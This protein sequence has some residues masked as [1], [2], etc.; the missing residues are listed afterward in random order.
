MKLTALSIL[1]VVTTSIF[2]GVATVKAYQ[3]LTS[4]KHPIEK[5]AAVTPHYIP[6]ILMGCGT[7][8]CI[9][10]DDILNRKRQKS[11]TSAYIL[12]DQYVKEYRKQIAER[13]GEEVE[14]EIHK[15]AIRKAHNYHVIDSNVPDQKLL[16]YEPLTD[17]YFERFER[18]VIDAEYHFNRNFALRSEASLD[19]LCAF[20][21]IEIKDPEERSWNMCDGYYWIDFDHVDTGRTRNGKKVF[22][23]VPVFL[24]ETEEY[25]EEIL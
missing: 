1:G 14:Q 10:T 12:L 13:Y 15:E 21:G 3:E 19:E 2:T 24:P 17:Q 23:I 5:V 9:V 22:E 6:A 11:I 18:D 16:W 7:I 25:W 20:L 4:D 8:A